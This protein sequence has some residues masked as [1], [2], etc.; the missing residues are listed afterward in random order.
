MGAWIAEGS[1]HLT[2]EHRYATP[3][4]MSLRIGDDDPC[5]KSMLLWFLLDFF[6]L[7]LLFDCQ[8]FHWIVKQKVDIK[9]NLFLKIHCHLDNDNYHKL[10]NLLYNFWNT[11]IK[12]V[13]F[14]CGW[15]RLYRLVRHNWFFHFFGN[16]TS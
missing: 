8:I 15:I 9:L 7:I 3:W 2:F 1:L 13:I 11:E 10:T 6:D 16:S 14:L 12:T 5:T 4:A